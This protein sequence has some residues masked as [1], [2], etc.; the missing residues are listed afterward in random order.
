MRQ[1]IQTCS[2]SR[3]RAS[4]GVLPPLSRPNIHPLYSPTRFRTTTASASITSATTA[5][6]VPHAQSH[7][8]ALKALPKQAHLTDST[9][10]VTSLRSAISEVQNLLLQIKSIKNLMDKQDSQSIG[11][12]YSG[13]TGRDIRF[14]S[15]NTTKV[16]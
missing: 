4:T 13:L 7:A 14:T 15:T 10:A 8:R 2:T 1:P 9:R 3:A 5:V 11:R 6:T 16:G 12:R